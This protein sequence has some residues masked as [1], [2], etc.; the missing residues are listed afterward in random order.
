MKIQVILPVQVLDTRSAG[1][2]PAREKWICIDP[3]EYDLMRIDNPYGK[4]GRFFIFPDGI[5]GAAE[6]W[7]SLMAW[8][9]RV[10]MVTSFDT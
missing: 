9:Q 7:W 8:H 5:A 6:G 10:V 2:Q 3:G 4:S 1:K